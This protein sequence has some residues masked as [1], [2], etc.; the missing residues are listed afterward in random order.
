LQASETIHRSWQTS[1]SGF[2]TTASN[3]FGEA[4]TPQLWQF[5]K[6]DYLTEGDE[7]EFD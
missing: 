6:E 1:Q 2:H 5:K 3:A 4:V 7:S